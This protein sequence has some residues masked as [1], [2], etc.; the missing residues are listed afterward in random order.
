MSR[1]A[2]EHYATQYA[3]NIQLL[4]QQRGAKVRPFVEEG[5][6]MG[7]GSSPVDQEGPFAARDPK[8]RGA[9]IEGME[10]D[11]DRRWVHPNTKIV[12][13]LV[14]KWDELR[15]FSDPKSK[16]VMNATYAIGRAIDDETIRAITGTNMVGKNGTTSRTLP[17]TQ[18]IAPGGTSLTYAKLLLAKEKLE[19]AEVDM[20][21]DPCCVIINAR[22]NRAL[23]SD[24]K[25]INRDFRGEAV[26]NDG[27][28]GKL[29]GF[30][31]IH[32]NRILSSG[33]S[34]YVP[35]FAKSGVYLGM[36]DDISTNV[37]RETGREGQPW[38]FYT[39]AVFGATRLEEQKIVRLDCI[40]T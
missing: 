28:V 38:L 7:E 1:N 9:R 36:W 8:G 25:V 33:S 13:P 5:H 21:M 2:P 17:A 31:F 16:K 40:N 4:L 14:Y 32:C 39:Q 10:A 15:Q 12:D 24:D 27:K 18:V 23:L 37:S 26:I 20:D 30:N 19:A 22:Q 3:T 6:H 11:K 29:L 34:D 35:V